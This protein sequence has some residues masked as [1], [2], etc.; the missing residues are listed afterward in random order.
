MDRKIITTG[1][2]W[3]KAYGYSRALRIGNFIEVAGTVAA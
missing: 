1:T 3:E 2:P